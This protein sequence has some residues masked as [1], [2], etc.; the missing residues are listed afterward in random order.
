MMPMNTLL[1]QR[2]IARFESVNQLY[3]MWRTVDE[4]IPAQVQGESRFP[5]L[6]AAALF[7]APLGEPK[8][9]EYRAEVLAVTRLLGERELMANTEGIINAIRYRILFADNPAD[10][11]SSAGDRTRSLTMVAPWLTQVMHTLEVR[12]PSA[13]ETP[14][15]TAVGVF[16]MNPVEGVRAPKGEIGLRG[17]SE[18]LMDLS[19]RQIAGAS[20]EGTLLGFMA[21]L[22]RHSGSNDEGQMFSGSGFDAD[23]RGAHAAMALI[24]GWV[25]Y[26]GRSDNHCGGTSPMFQITP[27]GREW[28]FRQ[29]P[30]GDTFA[31]F[32]CIGEHTAFLSEED[33]HGQVHVDTS[34]GAV[35]GALSSTEDVRGQ[36]WRVDVGQTP[37]RAGEVYPASALAY[38]TVDGRSV[39]PLVAIASQSQDAQAD[40]SFMTP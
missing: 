32:N 9:E 15:N 30:Y 29:K 14:T 34:T 36:P 5:Y 37:L 12:F 24:R 33:G 38:T 40:A 23:G 31:H 8:D 3:E 21:R 26:R 16:V 25:D 17:H 1:T 18:H 19:I 11:L 4:Q 10:R 22:H 13:G 28:L 20:A 39:Q 27:A 35:L 6:V 2:F 7:T